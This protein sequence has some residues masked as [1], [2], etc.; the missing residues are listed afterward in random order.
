MLVAVATGHIP[1]IRNQQLCVAPERQDKDDREA[2]QVEDLSGV[3][4]R[5]RILVWVDLTLA[6][7]EKEELEDNGQEEAVRAK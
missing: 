6:P 3:K 4:V 5:S 2:A 1:R 7:R